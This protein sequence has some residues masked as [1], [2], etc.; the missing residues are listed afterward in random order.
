MLDQFDLLLYTDDGYVITKKNI[1]QELLQPSNCP[2]GYIPVPGNHLY[3]TAYQGSHGFCVMKY[4]AKVDTNGDGKGDLAVY[5]TG[6]PA[7]DGNTDYCKGRWWSSSISDIIYYHTWC[8]LEYYD[9]SAYVNCPS[10]CYIENYSVVS[11]LEGYPIAHIQQSNSSEFDA[12]NAC[13]SIPGGHL[14]TN[15]EWM[16][17]V[18]NIELVPSNWSGEEV[19]VGFLPHGN[20][21]VGRAVYGDDPEGTGITK[22]TLTLTNNQIIWDLSGNV[23][24]WTDNSLSYNINNPPRFFDVNDSQ[25][26]SG[27]R[28]YDYSKDGGTG[29]HIKWDDLGETQVLDYKDLFLLTSG[30]YKAMLPDNLTVDN[31][32]GR[33]Y[34]REGSTTRVFARGGSWHAGPS[35]GVLALTLSHPSTYRSS[36]NGARCVVVSQ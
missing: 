8:H 1:R 23:Y 15:D 35:A 19:G 5:N 2:E 20:T 7:I 29:Y 13:E 16:T 22:R 18:R 11:S 36:T 26:G 32:V 24:S 12:K 27:N 33:I 34:L 4:E 14:I 28:W 30:N 17:I 21:N 25:V 6:N 9:G 10:E 31:G 3:G